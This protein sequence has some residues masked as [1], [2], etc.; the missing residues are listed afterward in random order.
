MQDKGRGL[1]LFGAPGSGKGTQA[2]VLQKEF[3]YAHISTGDMIRGEIANG[4]P[5]GLE[6]KSIVESGAFVSDDLMIRMIKE[7]ISKLPADQGFILDGFPRTQAQAEALDVMLKELG[8]SVRVLYL[9]VPDE[10]ILNRLKERVGEDGAKRADDDPAVVKERLKTYRD[11]TEPL[12]PY[13]EK[14]DR[15]VSLD[16]NRSPE[17]VSVAIKEVLGKK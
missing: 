3:G 15:L 12:L 8:R 1:V 10:A 13:Y 2:K 11:K 6:V 14:T 16:G 9:N 17:E 4:T 7:T 5:L